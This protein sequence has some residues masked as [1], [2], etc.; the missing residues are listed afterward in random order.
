VLG[1]QFDGLRLEVH[2]IDRFMERETL[3]NEQR[4]LRI[5][6]GVDRQQGEETADGCEAVVGGVLPQSHDMSDSGFPSHSSER[7]QGGASHSS[8]SLRTSQGRLP[9][10]NFSVFVSEDPQFWRLKCESYFDM[11]GVETSIWVKVVSLHFEAS[12][13][14]WL[15]S[16]EHRIRGI[17]WEQL[18]SMVHDHFGRDQHEALI[19]QLFHIRQSGTVVEYVDQFLELVDQLASYEPGTNQLYYAMIFVDGLREDIK[20]MEMIQHPSNLDSA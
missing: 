13:A 8:E 5:F 12:A 3:E 16:V 11:Y 18:C 14:R 7:R 20:S 4:G 2:R 15:Q 6:S 10:I 19:R 1:K 17:S 9:K